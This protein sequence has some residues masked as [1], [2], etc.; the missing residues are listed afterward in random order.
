MVIFL[1]KVV[2]LVTFTVLVGWI[3]NKQRVCQVVRSAMKKLK[4]EVR[5][6]RSGGGGLSEWGCHR[7]T[8]LRR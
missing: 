6:A 8:S 1:K 7:R 4:Q 2:A 5:I 3:D